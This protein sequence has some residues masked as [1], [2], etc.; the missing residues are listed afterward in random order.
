MLCHFNLTYYLYALS[1]QSHYRLHTLVLFFFQYL[2]TCSASITLLVDLNL[3]HLPIAEHTDPCFL[4]SFTLLLIFLFFLYTPCCF[5]SLH[6]LLDLVSNYTTTVAV[7]A[8]TSSAN[9]FIL[10][11]HSISCLHTS[12]ILFNFLLTHFNL[13]SIVYRR[14]RPAAP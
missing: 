11:H 4:F 7:N 10:L 3:S 1:S 13:A 12:L 14:L 8:F 6:S 5:L 2:I 9:V